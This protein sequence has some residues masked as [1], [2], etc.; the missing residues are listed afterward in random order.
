MNANRVAFL[1]ALAAAAAACAPSLQQRQLDAKTALEGLADSEFEEAG[2]SAERVL[3]R[4]DGNPYAA[5]VAAIARYK[6]VMHD[7]VSD[8][9]TLV[10]AAEATGHVNA[11]YMKSSFA[12]AEAELAKID[13]LLAVAA[14]EPEI[15]LELCV[16]CMRVDWNR[17]GRI[18]DRDRALL[19]VEIDEHEQPI[20]EGDPMRRPTFRFD[21]GD[22]L[23]A[24]AFV[25]FQRAALD[26]AIAYDWSDI[27][28]AAR[29][30][31]GDDLR[32]RLLD[33]ARVADAKER[34][35]EGLDLADL[36]RE[37]YLAETDDDREWLPNPRQED[38]PM[39]MPVDEALYE[40]WENVVGDVRRLVRGEE[41]LDVSEIARLGDHEWKNPPRGYIDVGRL[42][43]DPHDI[44]LRGTMCDEIEEGMEEGNRRAV[45]AV[46]D[47]L[48]NDAY[49]RKMPRSPLPSRLARMQREVERGVESLGRKLRYLLWVN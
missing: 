48:L 33:A 41:G 12:G 44:V 5:A 45:E 20:P 27:L 25:A 42:L 7:L 15:S 49:V 3:E 34:I 47:G 38:H 30:E 46:L 13:D 10:I 32:I 21:R 2:E 22:F 23:W 36:A 17:N 14:A 26:L 19:E 16:A 28:G 43:D 35:L 37:A 29:L 4:D 1:L 24:R 6:A 18:D 31:E 9:I 39:P 8:V 11:R 40:T